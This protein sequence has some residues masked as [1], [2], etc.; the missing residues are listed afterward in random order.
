VFRCIAKVMHA[1]ELKRLT[2]WN[3]EE[4]LVFDK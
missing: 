4:L 3:R 1:E 2:I